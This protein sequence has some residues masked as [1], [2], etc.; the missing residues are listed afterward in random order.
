MVKI[1]D[2]LKEKV[3]NFRNF[4][5]DELEK[6]TLGS[7]PKQQLMADLD[8]FCTDNN[9]FVNVAVKLAQFGTPDEA[10]KNFMNSYGINIDDHKD[11]IDYAKLCRYI[12]MFIT[13]VKE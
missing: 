4:I 9:N 7:L 3:K 5:K 13:I 10:I 2:F 12:K 8:F 6:T 11:Q 1:D